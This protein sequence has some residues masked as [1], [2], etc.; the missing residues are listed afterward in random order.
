MTEGTASRGAEATYEVVLGGQEEL[1]EVPMAMLLQ[2]VSGWGTVVDMLGARIG[3]SG[4]LRDEYRRA[5][6]T[7]ATGEKDQEELVLTLRGAQEM[8]ELYRAKIKE[9]GIDQG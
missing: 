8:V 2:L 6:V 5:T 4:T 3:L 9:L 7:V 1:R